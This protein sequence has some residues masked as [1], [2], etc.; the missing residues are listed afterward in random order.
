MFTEIFDKYLFVVISDCN[1]SKGLK[2]VNETVDGM[3]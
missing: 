3:M 2:F 1:E